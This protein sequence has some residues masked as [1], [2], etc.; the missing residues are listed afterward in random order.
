MQQRFRDPVCGMAVAP[1][2]GLP[3]H[4]GGQTLYFCSGGCLARFQAAGAPLPSGRAELAPHVPRR[5]IAYF[6]MEVALESKMPTYSGGLGVLAGDLLRACAELHVPIIGVSLVYH[7]G[8]F[9]QSLS[10]RGYQGERPAGWAPQAVLHAEQP[11]ITLE[12]EG[13]TVEVCARRYEVRGPDGFSVPVLLLDTDLPSNSTPDRRITDA[14]Y[15]GDERMRLLQEA[16][17]G[18]GGVRMLAALGHDGIER[19]HLNEG[20]AAFAPVELILTR[21][22][23]EPFDVEY[24]RSRCVFTTH[25]PVPA[26]HDRFD[27][28]FV[29]RVLGPQVP[30]QLLRML[31]GD[32]ELNMTRLALSTSS[33]VNGVARVHQRTSAGLFPGHAFAHITNGVH[34]TTWTSAPFQALYDRHI[35]EWREDPQMLRKA[36]ALPAES[37]WLAHEVAKATLLAAVRARTGRDLSARPLTIGFARRATGYKRPELIFHDLD[38][39]RALARRFPLQLVFAGKAHPHD[40]SGKDAIRH[41]FEAAASLEGILPVVYLEDHDL[42]LAKILV[43]GAD[44]WLN[45]P[46]RPLEASGTSGMKAAH[47]GVPSL[48]VLDGWWAEG[49]IEGVTGWAIGRA[50]PLDASQAQVEDSRSLYEALESA[51]AP[52]FFDDRR[53]WGQVMKQ[54]IAFNAAYF[55]AQRMV[56]QYV[57]HAYLG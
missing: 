30:E 41:V 1:A 32:D 19:F 20:H 15:G 44:L 55:N 54:A 24:A 37:V 26:G 9:A 48:S 50:A 29:S 16:V 25:T 39:L 42:D 7:W 28:G 17:L 3:L 34:S 6:S 31:G 35:P 18:I 56:Q 47:N 49:H 5:R 36:V 43:A 23:G 8:Y 53:G 11:T 45:C 12:L 4:V 57:T 38:R 10:A 2:T 27:Y 33:Y 51:I 40:Q 13:R 22:A 46:L 21:G 52:L 14:L